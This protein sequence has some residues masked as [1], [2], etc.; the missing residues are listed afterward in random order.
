MNRLLDRLE[1]MIRPVSVP[2]V[3]LGLIVLQILVFLMAQAR[4]DLIGQLDLV[5][6]NVLRGEIWRI[7]TFLIIPPIGNPI[8]A[9][10]FWYLFYLMGTALE[11]Y[12]GV[13]RYNLYLLIGFLT[14]VGVAFLVPDHAVSNAFLQGSVFLAFAFLNPDFELYLFFLLPIRIKWL[15]LLTWISYGVMAVTGDVSTR[16]V[17]LASICNFVLF[18]AADIG[19][20]IRG[21]RRR[22]AYQ[23]QLIATASEKEFYHCCLVCGI[24]DQTHPQMDF[25]Y[26]SKCEGACGYCMDHLHDHTHVSKTEVP[27]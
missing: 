16:L 23:A 11:G 27:S 2:Q 25:S 17:I 14:T 24:T 19:Y 7:F 1:R 20:K 26:C 15:A 3:T 12:W 21:A 6:D 22:M 5:P 10:F 8:C 18:F 9:A 4:R 13:A